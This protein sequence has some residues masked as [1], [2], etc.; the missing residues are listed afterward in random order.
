[1]KIK[2]DTLNATWDLLVF[3]MVI[4]LLTCLPGSS[5]RKMEKEGTDQERGD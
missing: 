4:A 1:M 2:M 5:A 3:L